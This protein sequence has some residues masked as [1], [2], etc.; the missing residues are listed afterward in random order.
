MDTR[1]PV[2]PLRIRAT[3]RRDAE[4]QTNLTKRRTWRGDGENEETP[5]TVPYAEFKSLQAKY[6]GLKG[7]ADGLQ[8]KLDKALADI[9]SQAEQYEGQLTEA[10]TSAG[11][12]DTE[13]KLLR[14]SQQA[15]TGENAR[16]KGQ[17]ELTNRVLGRKN[18]ALSDMLADGLLRV[19]GLDD[20]GINAYLDKMAARFATGVQ[21]E[22]ERQL[23]G[24]TVT[25][26]GTEKLQ[27]TKEQMLDK[28]MTL[29]PQSKEYGELSAAYLAVV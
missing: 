26:A 29:D 22:A 25:P 13:A 24:V 17:A 28:L 16:L 6:N 4:A 11:R 27:L 1:I 19:D 10:R 12:L 3:R 8:T 7:H 15:L 5:Q 2:S 21:S 18:Q 9:A 23:N 14:D 20:A